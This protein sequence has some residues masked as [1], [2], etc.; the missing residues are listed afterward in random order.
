MQEYEAIVEKAVRDGVVPGA[1]FLARDKKVSSIVGKEEY[2][3]SPN[4]A[5][6]S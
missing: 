4:T 5:E 1:V 6:E 2:S 3:K